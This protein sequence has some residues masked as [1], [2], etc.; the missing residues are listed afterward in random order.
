M[1][2]QRAFDPKSTVQW[3]KDFKITVMWA[4]PTHLNMLISVENVK[5][6]DIGNLEGNSVFWSTSI[7]R[8]FL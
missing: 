5:E 2:I 6:F 3:I 8:A 4:T 1:L 7:I